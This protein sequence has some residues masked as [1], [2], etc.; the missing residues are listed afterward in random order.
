MIHKGICPL[1]LLAVAVL[2]VSGC[3]SGRL[4][5][6]VLKLTHE[7]LQNRPLQIRNICLGWTE[8]TVNGVTYRIHFSRWQRRNGSTKS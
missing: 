6:R 5:A 3:G 4:P 1:P 8:A 2:L 7:S